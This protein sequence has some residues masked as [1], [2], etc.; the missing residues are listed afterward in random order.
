MERKIS[1][2]NC[3]KC[4]Q[5]MVEGYVHS[6]KQIMWSLDGISRI[7]DFYDEYLVP[8]S[9][10]RSNKVPAL[11]CKECKIVLFEY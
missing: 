9:F 5:V 7:F 6:P 2:L 3:P 8:M 10:R 4:G 1:N 11:R